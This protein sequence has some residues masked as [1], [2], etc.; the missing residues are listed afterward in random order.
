LA[1]LAAEDDLGV[2]H[3]RFDGNLS[4]VIPTRS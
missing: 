1:K 3:A 4:R 2:F